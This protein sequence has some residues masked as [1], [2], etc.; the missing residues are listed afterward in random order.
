LLLGQ[1]G[2]KSGILL[3]DRSGPRSVPLKQVL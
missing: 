1:H 3:L 2:K